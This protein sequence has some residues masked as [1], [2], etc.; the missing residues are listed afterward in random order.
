VVGALNGLME[1]GGRCRLAFAQALL[2]ARWDANAQCQWALAPPH[3]LG[4][5]DDTAK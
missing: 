5:Y 1:S 4:A 2:K 3:G